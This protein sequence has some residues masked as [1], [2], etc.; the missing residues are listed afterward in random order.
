M[1][2][3]HSLIRRSILFTVLF[4]FHLTSVQAKPPVPE[5]LK[6]VLQSF[7]SLEEAYREKEWKEAEESLAIVR[8]RFNRSL[9]VLLKSAKTKSD[10]KKIAQFGVFL[11]NLKKQ[12]KKKDQKKIFKSFKLLQLY[13]VDFIEFYDYQHHP[14]L[15]VFIE[16]LE[17]MRKE[18]EFDEIE[19]ESE[20]ML[21]MMKTIKKQL[22]LHGVSEENINKFN[23]LLEQ[24]GNNATAQDEKEVRKTIKIIEETIPK[25]VSTK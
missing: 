15:E 12:L 13:V 16:E 1:K 9:P 6:A 25:L 2:I 22:L 7:S 10:R 5:T 20:E 24:L 4:V 19:E 17:E 23:H 14:F 8:K 11:K 3:T 18:I 21:T